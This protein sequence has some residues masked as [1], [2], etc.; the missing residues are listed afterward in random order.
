MTVY[1]DGPALQRPQDDKSIPNPQRYLCLPSGDNLALSFAAE[2]HVP[3]HSPT[4][5]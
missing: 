3:K 2:N 4:L 1:F 5:S